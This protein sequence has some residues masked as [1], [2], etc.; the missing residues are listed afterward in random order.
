MLSLAKQVPPYMCRV[1]QTRFR[2][3][4]CSKYI[5]V[6]SFN[7]LNQHS[8]DIVFLKVSSKYYTLEGLLSQRLIQQE[9]QERKWD[10]YRVISVLE[11]A[12][13]MDKRMITPVRLCGLSFQKMNLVSS[14]CLKLTLCG[15]VMYSVNHSIASPYHLH[16][17]DTFHFSKHFHICNFIYSSYK[18]GMKKVR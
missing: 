6:T 17:N 7:V 2:P 16:L 18:L 5:S 15:L 13:L 3:M 14:F 4:K 8:L 11:G 9:G 1:G 12:L 10:I